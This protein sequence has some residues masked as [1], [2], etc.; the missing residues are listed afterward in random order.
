MG[1]KGKRFEPM[2]AG[3]TDGFVRPEMP[4]YDASI[5]QGYV[6]FFSMS[7]SWVQKKKVGHILSFI[8]Q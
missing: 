3:D 2:K 8:Q 4:E 5:L 7:R 1:W 6:T